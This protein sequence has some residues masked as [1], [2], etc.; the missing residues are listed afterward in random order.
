MVW[1]NQQDQGLPF[2]SE[3]WRWRFINSQRE[4]W[5]GHIQHTCSTS[6][7][8]SSPPNKHSSALTSS[9]ICSRRWA[10]PRTI[11]PSR[12]LLSTRNSTHS[13][14][15]IFSLLH[16]IGTHKFF[17]KFTRGR[18][19]GGLWR[20]GRHIR[21]IVLSGPICKGLKRGP[22]DTAGLKYAPCLRPNY[23]AGPPAWVKYGLHRCHKLEVFD[24]L[25]MKR[26]NVQWENP[27]HASQTVS[28]RNEC[29]IWRLR[30]HLDF[31]A[32][33]TSNVLEYSAHVER[34]VLGLG[35][36]SALRMAPSGWSLVPDSWG[37]K[38]WIIL[39]SR[40]DARDQ[41]RREKP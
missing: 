7:F 12:E 27:C 36:I 35:E 40:R 22:R 33:Q 10:P 4:I 14:G 23:G 15:R 1:S 18:Y 9:W 20:N 31:H 19:H 26:L 21:S 38:I 3:G 5:T 8:S 37:D 13:L 11:S 16:R 34:A 6:F 17:A 41:S 28:C 25:R 24:F 29:T 30:W 32:R 39:S 2:Q